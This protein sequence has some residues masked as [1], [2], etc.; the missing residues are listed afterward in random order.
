M[1]ERE[2]EYKVSVIVPVYNVSEYLDDC[3]ASIFK[4]SISMDDVE[5][6]LINDGS[7]DDSLDICLQYAG[8]YSNIKVYSKKMKDY[9]R[10]AILVLCT[11]MVNILLI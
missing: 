10:H 7:S 1:S 11:R 4:Q 3:I 9:R 2:F 5:V 6:L 8:L